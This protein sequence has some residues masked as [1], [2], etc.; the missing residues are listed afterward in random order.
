MFEALLELIARGLDVAGRARDIEDVRSIVL[1]NPGL[2][3]EYTRRWLREF[4]KG[5][6]KSLLAHFD[7]LWTHGKAP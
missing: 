3:T 4:E 1:K 5:S 6:E 2:D 7:E